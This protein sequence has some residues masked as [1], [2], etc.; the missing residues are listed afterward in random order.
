MW[1]NTITKGKPK[2]YSSYEQVKAINADYDNCPIAAS[3]IKNYKL[4]KDS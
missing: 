1:T 2:S 3:F 4:L